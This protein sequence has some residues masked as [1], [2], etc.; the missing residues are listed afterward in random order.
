MTVLITG[1]G[2]FLGLAIV[3]LLL[4][5]GD[6]VHTLQRSASP[7]LDALAAE[8]GAERLVQH[9]GDLTDAGV[10]ERAA[11]GCDAIIHT[12][13]K[14]GVWGSRASYHGPNVVGTQHVLAACR[15]CGVEVLVHTSTPSVVH[16][17]HDVAGVDHTA[18]LAETFETHYPATKA[19]A[20]RLVLA[21]NGEAIP[22]ASDAGGRHERVLHTV[23]LRPHLIWGPGDNHLVPRLVARARAGKLKLVGD[24]S[25][26]VDGTYIDN[27]ASAHVAALD[28][29]LEARASR[30][31]AACAGKAYFVTNGEPMPIRQ[32][33]DGIL[34]AAGLPPVRSA[35]PPAV[36][37]LAGATLEGVH[38]VFRP[39]VEPMMTRFVARQLSTAHWYDIEATRRDLRWSPD[40]STAAGLERLAAS[41]AEEAA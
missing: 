5:R 39:D 9:R 4:G 24:G 7:E 1:G 36:A 23:A 35:V 12:A 31:P 37:W 10:V 21:A 19:E 14:A 27:A 8:H 13:A 29:L 30:Q 20:E 18:P 16:A 26:L 34:G 41:F 33:I 22:G 40:V 28:R 38:R 25:N 32:L 17:G 15:S 2:G 11:E 3:R 6:V